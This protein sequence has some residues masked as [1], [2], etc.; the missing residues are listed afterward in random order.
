MTSYLVTN[1]VKV[2]EGVE[3]VQTPPS[4]WKATARWSERMAFHCHVGYSTSRAF[5]VKQ[6]IEQIESCSI[7]WG[8]GSTVVVHHRVLW[9]RHLKG[10]NDD[11]DDD[12]P[13]DEGY[14]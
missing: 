12:E 6:E 3:T 5:K 2:G 13:S 9:T 8:G 14:W 1:V 4:S 7:N 11:D 10:H